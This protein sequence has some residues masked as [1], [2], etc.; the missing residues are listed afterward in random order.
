MPVL[1]Y[2][3]PKPPAA[4]ASEGRGGPATAK[5]PMRTLLLL[6]LPLLLVS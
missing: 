1:F 4:E 2:W 5:S 6:A 3:E